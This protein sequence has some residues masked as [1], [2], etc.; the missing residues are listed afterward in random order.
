MS[1]IIVGSI[2]TEEEGI[3]IEMIQQIVQST[4]AIIN[5]SNIRTIDISDYYI[6]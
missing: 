4:V 2:I 3:G 5:V 6:R 1:L